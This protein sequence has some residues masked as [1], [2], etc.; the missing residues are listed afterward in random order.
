MVQDHPQQDGKKDHD[1]AEPGIC[2]HNEF[3]GEN[4][5]RAGEQCDYEEQKKMDGF[6]VSHSFVTLIKSE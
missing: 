4:G 5:Y 1:L 3:T 6:V 2:S